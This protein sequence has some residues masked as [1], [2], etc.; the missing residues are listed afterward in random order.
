MK[1][2]KNYFKVVNDSITLYQPVSL[3][4]K[5]NPEKVNKDYV[6]DPVI[7]LKLQKLIDTGLISFQVQQNKRRGARAWPADQ[8][9]QPQYPGE[10][11]VKLFQ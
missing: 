8:A 5:E 9:H 7:T 1:K 11:G 2:Y 3:E 6:N 4:T 10:P